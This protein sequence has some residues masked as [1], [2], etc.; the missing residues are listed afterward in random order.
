M[1]DP[2]TNGLRDLMTRQHV[3]GQI[4][5]LMREHGDDFVIYTAHAIAED[6][7]RKAH[8]AYVKERDVARAAAIDSI[9]AG[10]TSKGT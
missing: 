1:A 10:R 9:N 6:K 2:L 7:R 3:R 5:A 4:A 8:D